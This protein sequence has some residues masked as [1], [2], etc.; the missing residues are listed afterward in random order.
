MQRF[1]CLKTAFMRRKRNMR[2]FI[3]WAAM[4]ATVLSAK[5]F[6]PNKIQGE[7]T[8]LVV[9]LMGP[10]G[11]GKG[12][13]AAPLSE[14]LEIPHI[15][16]GDLFRANMR[17]ETP[18]GKKA[19]EY[20]DEGKLVPDD[21]VLGMLFAR[22]ENADCKKG[23][24]LDGCPRT[25]PQAEVL[26]RY[27]DQKSWPAIVINL[28]IADALLIERISGRIACRA[29]NQIY[30]RVFNPPKKAGLCDQCEG[31]L[32][33]REDDQAAILRKRLEAYHTQTAPLLDYYRIK[34]GTLV[35]IE[36]AGSKEK[37]FQ[38]ILDAVRVPV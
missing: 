5:E 18:L 22:I 8:P 25:V 27:L 15:S 17:E 32:Y 13:H 28:K 21:V 7:E 23:Y 30:H 6:P 16:T 24:I 19:K 10:P 20:I 36:A 29:C 35:E 12:T 1:A 26:D 37:I 4:V 38:S 33:Q 2:F 11:A 31:D 3:G 9:I 14:Q 34:Q